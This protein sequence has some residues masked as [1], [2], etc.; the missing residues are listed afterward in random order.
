MKRMRGRTGF[1]AVK[2]DLEKD[3]DSLSWD[4]IEDTLRAVGIP[5][6]LCSVIMDSISIA[7]TRV[8]C[9]VDDRSILDRPRYSS[10]LSTITLYI[11]FMRRTVG[12]SHL[13]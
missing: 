6:W 8:L 3:Y 2:M 1:V 7:S 5:Y 9:N 10:R 11:H 13:R 4:F 12:P